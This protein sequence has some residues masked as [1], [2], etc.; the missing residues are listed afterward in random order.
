[1]IEIIQT[2]KERGFLKD[3]IPERSGYNKSGEQNCG[4]AISFSP[5][6]NARTAKS[7]MEAFQC[8]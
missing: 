5:W 3:I 7:M 4:W 6:F 2:P 8:S 1:M